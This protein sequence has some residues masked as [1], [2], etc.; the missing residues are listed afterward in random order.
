MAI[1]RVTVAAELGDAGEALR[2]AVD[3]DPTR[4]PEGLSSRRAQVNLDL[5]WAAP[6]TSRPP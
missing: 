2:V 5:A 4:L 6:P 3:V 1:H